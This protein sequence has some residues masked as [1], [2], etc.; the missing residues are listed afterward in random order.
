[1]NDRRTALVTGGAKRV[2]R[3][4]VERLSESGFDVAFTYNGSA[5]EA[6]ELSE[7]L[8]RRGHRVVIQQIDLTEPEHATLP[9]LLPP[10]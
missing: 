9:P 2:G 7:A 6:R 8:S 10:L 3:A 4:I 1:M 5:D